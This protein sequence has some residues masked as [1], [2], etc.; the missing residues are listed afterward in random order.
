MSADARAARLGRSLRTVPTAAL[1]G[2]VDPAALRV[3]GWYVAGRLA[4]SPF[5]GPSG[6]AAGYLDADE[7]LAD[8]RVD[9]AVVDGTVPA[10]VELLPELRAAGLLVLLPTA[11]PL[12]VGALRAARAVDG[13]EAAV[14]LLRRWEPWVRTVAAAVPLAGGPPLQVTVRGWPRGPQAAAELVDV[15]TSW[16]GEVVAVVAAPGPLPA[17]A[18]PDGVAV[19]WSLLTATGATVLVA[20]G[21]GPPAVRLSFPAARLEGGPAGVRWAGGDAVPLSPEPA[22]CPPVPRGLAVG[23]VASAVALAGAR[24]G[25]D[26]PHDM[27]PAGLGDLLVAARVLEALRESARREL[28]VPTA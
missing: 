19:A 2:D 8:G 11:D 3:A 14:G 18:L 7:L 15:V 22:W 26:L 1:V 23:Q 21:D 9:L 5:S 28:P 27:R 16:C 6:D 10:L 24:G 25:A 17:E 12:E 20:H 4:A 13:P